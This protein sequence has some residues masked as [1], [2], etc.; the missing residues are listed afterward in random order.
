VEVPFR[1]PTAIE[2]AYEFGSELS[3][4][5]YVVQFVINFV[6]AVI[7]HYVSPLLDGYPDSYPR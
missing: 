1:G 5:F 2:M 7:R 4:P 3:H 6:Q